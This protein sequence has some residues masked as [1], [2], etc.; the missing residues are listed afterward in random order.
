MFESRRSR[1]FLHFFALFCT[2]FFPQIGFESDF[3]GSEGLV[4]I[5][6]VII[7]FQPISTLFSRLY[8]F[9]HTLHHTLYTSQNLIFP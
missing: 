5:S 7:P 9:H 1:S 2:F 8:S 4:W 3:C 6:F